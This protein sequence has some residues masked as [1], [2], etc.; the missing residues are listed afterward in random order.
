ML[1]QPHFTIA[2]AH[3]SPA[4]K[5]AIASTSPSFLASLL[6]HLSL[7]LCCCP[8][9]LLGQALGDELRAKFA[10]T[11]TQVLEIVRHQ[12]L[13]QDPADGAS[14]ELNEKIRLRAPYVA[15]LNVLQV[16]ALRNL[17]EFSVSD[18]SGAR[19]LYQPSES[20]IIELL[21]RDPHRDG[22]H[23]F[24]AAMDDTLMITIKGIAA[25]MQNTG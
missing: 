7:L 6:I 5:P 21:S 14:P 8:F 9:I 4:P 19:A 20:E 15:P 1:L 11:K 17:R 13:L 2:P 22:K 24:Q 12:D 16:Q 3:V 25:G 10:A 23:P 18:G